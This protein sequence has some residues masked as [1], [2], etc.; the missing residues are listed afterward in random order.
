VILGDRVTVALSPYDLSH[1][2]ITYRHK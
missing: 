2:M 1:G